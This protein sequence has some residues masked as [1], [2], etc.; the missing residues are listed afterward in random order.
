MSPGYAADLSEDAAT[1]LR[2]PA[3]LGSSIRMEDDG[4]RCVDCGT[5]F[6]VDRRTKLC[7]LVHEATTS[8]KSEIQ[9]FWGDL[10]K[11]LYEAND[12]ALTPEILTRQIDQLEDL[13]H[14]RRQSCVVEMPLSELEGKRVLEVGSG[15]GGHSC[16]F[17]KHGALVTAVDITAARAAS[18]AQKFAL[19]RCGG[20]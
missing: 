20:A 5:T 7:A 15:S 6:Q 17:K 16:I 2:C 1:V 3:C 4:L 8:E 18:T 19:A 10:Y 13:F 11:Q 9:T 14:K 12:S